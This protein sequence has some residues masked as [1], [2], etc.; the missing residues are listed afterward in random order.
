MECGERTE[1]EPAISTPHCPRAWGT[2]EDEVLYLS[3]DILRSNKMQTSL[4]WQQLVQERF[5]VT[6]YMHHLLINDPCSIQ[7]WPAACS[8]A[9]LQHCKKHLV[10]VTTM[11]IDENDI[12]T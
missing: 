11:N 7:W 2:F 9:L 8:V 12:S 10:N 3:K 4:P 1:L 5:L 6:V